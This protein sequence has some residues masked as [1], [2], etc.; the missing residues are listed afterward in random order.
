MI[1]PVLTALLTLLLPLSPALTADKPA[2]AWK[3]G[4]ATAAITPKT[5]MW[6]AGYA[7]RTAP[8]EGADT[9]LFAKALV[10]EDAGGERLALVT[11]DLV[12][13]PRSVRLAVA[14]RVAKEHGI[15]PERLV[16]N[17]SH[18]HC[19][20]E[21][22][23]WRTSKTDDADRR[24]VEAATYC[25]E[26][27]NTLVRLVGE[28]FAQRVPVEAAYS[29][30]RCG[31]AMNRRTPTA[32]G[33][34]NFPNPAGPVDHRVPV[35][36]LRTAE[37]SKELAVVFG[38]ACH[39]TTLSYQKF[40]GDYAGYAQ[41]FIEQAHPGA[42]A[43][44]VNGC[45]GDQNPY[46]RR[47]LEHAETH[48]RT[49]ALAVETALETEMKPVAG[50]LQAAYREIPLKY[51]TLPTRAELEIRAKSSDKLDANLATNL[52]GRLD[53]GETLPSDYPYPVQVVRLGDALTL[54]AL[55]G[56][57]VVDYSLR[58][59]REIHDPMVWIAGYSNDVMTY[60]PSRRVWDEGG[61]E[62]AD[63]MKYNFHPAR[64][65]PET[66]EVIVKTVHEL[67]A[68]LK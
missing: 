65:A 15:A 36:R 23:V 39:C 54:V 66:E 58:L 55:A 50:A 10:I 38:Y 60:I 6:M 9:E 1:K 5:P 63:A 11:L 20:P 17:A 13:V 25:T 22:R 67:R 37:T 42:T 40:N 43:L 27:E 32:T 68:S 3:A 14:D 57:V 34:K 48:G 47:K 8:A 46:P 19:G 45:S 16:L 29:Q 30:A 7:S 12:S 64:W 44:F 49:L 4:V 31:F 24:T 62:G 51:D 21:L 26:L 61:Y 41:A 53:A 2:P 28:A 18:T 56:E 33:F 52:L 35:L 59:Q